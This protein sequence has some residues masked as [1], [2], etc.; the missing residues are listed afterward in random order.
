MNSE[1]SRNR[2]VEITNNSGSGRRPSEEHNDILPSTTS[3]SSIYHCAQCWAVPT[4]HHIVCKP[5]VTHTR[6]QRRAEVFLFIKMPDTSGSCKGTNNGHW[7]CIPGQRAVLA[8]GGRRLGAKC[9]TWYLYTVPQ[10]HGIHFVIRA[11]RSFY[12]WSSGPMG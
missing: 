1:L 2:S 12:V 3:I 11:C 5:S 6:D 8:E 10:Y 7:Q 9:R 4:L